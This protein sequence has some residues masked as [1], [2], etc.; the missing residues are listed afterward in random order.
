CDVLSNDE[1]STE[2]HNLND[3]YTNLKK[4]YIEYIKTF[5][6]R[7]DKRRRKIKVLGKKFSELPPMKGKL[8]KG[9]VK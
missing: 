6:Y 8:H 3:K 9:R 2:Y 7:G 1:L 4:A 5:S